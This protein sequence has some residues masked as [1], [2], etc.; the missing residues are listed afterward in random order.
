MDLLLVCVIAMV[1]TM[2][3]IPPLMRVATR[4]RVL[5][6]PAA[7]KVHAQPIPRVGGVAMAIGTLLPLCLWLPRE[8]TLVAYV[9]AVMVLL[10]FGVWDD[11][12]TLRPLTKFA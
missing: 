4:L 5:D 6:D 3:L 7:R 12:V 11:R 2:V 10:G 1:V 8:P 9:A